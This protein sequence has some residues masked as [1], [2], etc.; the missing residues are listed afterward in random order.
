MSRIAA[1]T[2][3]TGF[4]G[5]H[6]IRS[7]HHDDWQIRM[8]TRSAPHLPELAD[9]PI[10]L[11]LGGLNDPAALATL[12]DGADTV[13]HLAGAVK[14][15][16]RDMFLRINAEGTANMVSAWQNAAPKADFTLVSSLAARAP[17]LSD[18]AFSKHAAEQKLADMPAEAQWRILRPA[19]IYGA[20]DSE[21]LKVL[22]LVG[23]YF[24]LMLNAP[25]ARIA[26]IDVRDAAKAIVSQIGT[27]QTGRIAE[28]TD[29]RRDGYK[30]RELAETAAAAVGHRPRV[31]RLP[32]AI[33]RAA[34]AFGGAR[35][36]LIGSSEMLTP[37][38]VREILYS[39]WSADPNL[40]V[41]VGLPEP[42]I[43]L[44]RGLTDMTKWA[45][46]EGLL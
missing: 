6:L 15:P 4:L 45:R 35:N 21:S 39:D 37:G 41:P 31:I 40:P 38:K 23:P 32:S 14:A 18:Y 46:A 28:L 8:L 9:I 13:L 43:S 27:I 26:M 42:Q 34:G 5:R 22:K 7:L 3:G 33:L 10:E 20:H 2:G 30:W 11:I 29:A 17:H 16:N 36:A 24:Q 44:F 19:A 12:C 1:L 25:D